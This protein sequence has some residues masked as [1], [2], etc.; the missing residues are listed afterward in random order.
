MM[1]EP[2]FMQAVRFFEA[3][4]LSFINSEIYFQIICEEEFQE[5]A[6]ACAY[7][8]QAAEPRQFDVQLSRV[9]R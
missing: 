5:R 3:G 4:R 9:H 1:G 7:T 2:G 8:Q 6:H